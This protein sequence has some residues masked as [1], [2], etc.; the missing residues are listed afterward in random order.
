MVG[1]ALGSLVLAVAEALS[2]IWIMPA[3]Q[4][5]VSFAILVVVLVVMP[6]GML[7]LLQKI[8]KA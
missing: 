3:M 2:V 4:D 6:G 5:F 1:V 8:R 7:G